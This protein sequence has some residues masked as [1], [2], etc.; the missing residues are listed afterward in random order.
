LEA[1]DAPIRLGGSPATPR[2]LLSVMP[3]QSVSTPASRLRSESHLPTLDGVRGL[4]ILVVMLGH[5]TIAYRPANQ[6]ELLFKRLLETGW[7]GVDLFFV[8]SGFLITGILLEAKGGDHYFRNFYARRTLRI[9]PLYYAFLFAFFIV[10][11][12]LHRPDPAGAFAA[13]QPS[14]WWFWTYLSN[15]QILFPDWVRPYPLTHFWTLAVEEQFYLVWPAVVL[16]TS[17]KGLIRVCIAAVFIALIVRIGIHLYGIP[18]TA[19]YRITPARIDTLAIGGLLAVLARDQR[20]WGK[21]SHAPL[22]ICVCLLLLS[23]IAIPAR[24]VEQSSFA[25]QTVGY[26]LIAIGAALLIALALDPDRRRSPVNRFFATR[27]MRT[28]GKYSYAIYVLHF[29]LTILLDRLGF[30][31]SSFPTVAGSEV[32]GAVAYAL[33]ASGISLL[34]ALASWNLFEKHFLRLKVL[35]PRRDPTPY[36]PLSRDPNAQPMDSR[37]IA[38]V[39]QTQK[40]L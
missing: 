31:I 3:D 25:M 37:V 1:T 29:P 8:L 26:P 6:G 17:R 40:V 24:A 34:L 27:T 19:A 14:Q 38:S 35:F 28:L 36:D 23:A 20:A 33:I 7:V 12:L 13:A 32:P 10:A 4:A 30:R 5:F 11:P 21:I 18:A 9:F 2:K 22:A 15:Y 16:L 39:A